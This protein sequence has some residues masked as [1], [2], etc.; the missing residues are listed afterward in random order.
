MGNTNNT[1]FL[2]IT[3]IVIAGF[4]AAAQFA[5]FS[6]FFAEL[7]NLYPSSTIGLGFL[8]S[9]ISFMGALCSIFAGAV[10]Q[11]WGA[12]RLIIIAAGLASAISPIQAEFLPL[13]IMLTLR[14]F[15]GISHLLIV[16]VAPTLI[17]QYSSDKHRNFALS[18][19]STFFGATF[20][21][22][23]YWGIGFVA[24][25]GLE[26]FFR[27]HGVMMIIA[28]FCLWLFLPSE[29]REVSKA[30][31]IWE[32]VQAHLTFYRSPFLFAPAM[33]WLFYTLTYVSLLTILPSFISVTDKVWA[34][35][36]MPLSGMLVSFT[37]GAWLLQKMTAVHVII[38]GFALATLALSIALISSSTIAIIAVFATLGFVQCGSFAAV[39]QLNSNFADRTLSNA[40]MSHMGNLG[41]VI[42]TP[43]LLFISGF[44]GFSGLII[45]VIILY[46]IA[47]AGHF[48]LQVRR[49][50]N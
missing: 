49:K 38:L 34:L 30:P 46:G 45:A 33:G 48:I 44:A 42:G 13:P 27:L 10:V 43:I 31:K 47:I 1:R 12:K 14:L 23:A 26:N 21:F 40:G 50:A 5:K 39:P 6:V 32:V 24:N 36:L 4:G 2:A 16:I 9:L 35:T 25:F 19:W 11:S 8:V 17:A 22:T 7:Q 29:A 15:E 20:A 3:I 28:T 18:I 41:N 37:I